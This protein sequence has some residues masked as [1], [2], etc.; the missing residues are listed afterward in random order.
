MLVI[1]EHPTI[2][3]YTDLALPYFLTLLWP[4]PVVTVV[5]PDGLFL[6]AMMKLARTSLLPVNSMIT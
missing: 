3:G 6:P 4:L 5:T 1:E 2:A